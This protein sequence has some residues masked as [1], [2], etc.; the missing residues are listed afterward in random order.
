MERHGPLPSG[1]A[2]PLPD[3]FD[4]LQLWE[5]LERDQVHLRGAAGPATK[6]SLLAV[7][8]K[9]RT[10]IEKWVND[11]NNRE[12]V[13]L[14]APEEI[15]QIPEFADLFQDFANFGPAT[16]K[17]LLGYLASKVESRRKHYSSEA[18]TH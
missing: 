10:A 1:G 17:A 13:Q 6:A 18:Q 15:V 16:R 5:S 4:D 11:E 2:A 9:V 14:L 3:W 12:L 8:H 7:V